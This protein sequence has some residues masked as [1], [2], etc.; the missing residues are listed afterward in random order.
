MD[1]EAFNAR[2]VTLGKPPHQLIESIP[3]ID[4]SF[5][6]PP[7]EGMKD[8]AG[9]GES[10]EGVGIKERGEAVLQHAVLEGDQ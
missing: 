10:A 8:L 5:S 7:L 6:D 9:E 4:N 1:D 3:S 2:Q